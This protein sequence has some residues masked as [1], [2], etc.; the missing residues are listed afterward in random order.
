MNDDD[1]E[2][3]PAKLLPEARVRETWPPR[4]VDERLSEL[5]AA[6]ATVPETAKHVFYRLQREATQEG[7]DACTHLAADLRNEMDG[8]RVDQKRGTDKI[9][10]LAQL[11]SLLR[12]EVHELRSELRALKRNEARP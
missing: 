4:H 2:T 12:D 8:L 6:G 5:I 9:F 10:E 7:L 1:R 11:N 3:S